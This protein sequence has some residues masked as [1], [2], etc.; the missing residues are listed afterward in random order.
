LTGAVRRRLCLALALAAAGCATTATLPGWRGPRTDHFDGTHFHNL[1]P[2]VEQP[3][4][5]VL[6][7]QLARDRGDWRDDTIPPAPPPP[8]RVGGGELR[9]TLVNHSTLLVQMDGVN[10][11]TD[12]VWS[13]RVGPTSAIGQRRHRP[14]GIRWEDLPPI[15]VVLLSHDHYD[16]FDVPTLRR[17]ARR[18][19]PRII[20]GLGNGAR[21]RQEGI[22]GGEE[23]DWWR[24]VT[25]A[26][27][28]RVTAVPAQHWSGRT[29]TDHCRTL[30][31]GFVIEG[32]DSVYFAGDTGWGSLFAL[33]HA[34][35]PRFRLALL[36]IAPFRPE[37]YMHRKHA[38]PADAVHA[39]QVLHAATSVAMHWGTVEL[40]DD[41]RMEPVDSLR[42]T[43][44]ELPARCRP[45]FLTP[46]NGE[47]VR[48]PPLP[49]EARL[50]APAD[51]A[52]APPASESRRHSR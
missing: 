40:G 3:V 25:I 29:L 21:L 4:Q 17:L 32:R 22:G 9:V 34:R 36:P 37:W 8:W 41:G 52:C 7:W 44:A 20:T 33:I 2:F 23:L 43:I 48:V 5:D 10:I 45:V 49:D 27:G 15:D 47:A 13:E 28:L 16:H 1:Q 14:P 30:W 39:A 51:S 24:S 42:A 12:P 38:S 35:Y 18:F 46:D 26:P 11:L 31:M 6:L 19:H 50:S